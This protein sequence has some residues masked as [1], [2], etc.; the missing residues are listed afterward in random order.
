MNTS[1]L[2]L[3]FLHVGTFHLRYT[4]E[5]INEVHSANELKDLTAD[6]TQQLRVHAALRENA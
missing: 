4:S 5:E 1:V 3:F 6:M 2:Y